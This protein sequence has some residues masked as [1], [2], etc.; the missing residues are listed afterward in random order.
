VD[1]VGLR[2]RLRQAQAKAG[3]IVLLYADE[4]E[5]LTHPYLAHAWAERGADLRVTAPGQARKVA[6]MGALDA[7]ARELIVHTSPTKRSA[8]FIGLLERLDHRFGPQPGQTRK[9]VVLVLDNGPV[10]TSKATTAALAARPWITIEWLPRYAPELNDIELSWRHL[11]RHYLAHRTFRDA[12]DLE[13][14]IHGAVANLNRERQAG[15]P[16]DKLPIA[17]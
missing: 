6:M 4:S 13:A 11:K 9:P 1:R 16:C 2:L 8:D 3:D 12:A 14:A 5:A 10:H 7:A 17:A 15:F